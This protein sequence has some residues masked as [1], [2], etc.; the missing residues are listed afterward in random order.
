MLLLKAKQLFNP[1]GDDSA[2][3][4]RVVN[5]NPSNLTNYENVKYSWAL[6]LYDR[7]YNSH[8]IPDKIPMG[9]DKLSYK[10]LEKV[11]KDCYDKILS[12]L[13]FLDSVQCLSLPYFFSYISASEINDCLTMQT[14]QELNHKKSYKY[15]IDS[16]IDKENRN[17]I[18]DYWK[19]CPELEKRN[20]LI[21]NAFQRFRDNPNLESFRDAVINTYILEGLFFWIGFNFFYLLESK[22]K[23]INTANQIRYI[24]K[25]EGLHCVIFENLIKTLKQESDVSFSE[26]IVHSIFDKAV[27]EEIKWNVY[28]F[29]NQILGFNEY[30]ID[31]YV[32]NL[33]NRR[34]K[35]IG[36]APLYTDPKYQNNPFKHLEDRGYNEKEGI[37]KS[38]YFE[39]TVTEYS[40]SSVFSSSQWD[41]V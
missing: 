28:L 13:V 23:M 22:H 34:L 3:A 31:V 24:Q 7:M 25:D 12:Y 39:K 20:S 1:E 30:S 18:Y 32:K 8:W 5:G 40:Q 4:K 38:N 15:I 9:E 2:F 26:K 10:N 41:E 6:N 37:E 27:Q 33:A 36:F 16:V 29:D 11:E 17:L 21:A 35:K 19:E 14:N